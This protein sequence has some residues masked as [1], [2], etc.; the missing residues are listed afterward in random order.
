LL[1]PPGVP[2]P[3]TMDPPPASTYTPPPLSFEQGSLRQAFNTMTMTPISPNEWYMDS[4]TSPQ[5]IGNQGNLSRILPSPS[6]YPHV[7]VGDGHALLIFVSATPLFP[8][9]L[10]RCNLT[11][12]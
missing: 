1:S 12:S 3:S 2:G 4:R 5:M 10:I 6:P 11:M 7:I 9:L 8:R